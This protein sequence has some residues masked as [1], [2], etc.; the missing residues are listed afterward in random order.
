MLIEPVM[1]DSC[2]KYNGLV[3][4]HAFL[5]SP[6]VPAFRPRV[7]NK[8]KSCIELLCSTSRGIFSV[9]LLWSV[10]SGPVAARQ[11]R[12]SH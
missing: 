8:G 10:G 4:T 6:R 7:A 12:P 3:P 9:V 2:A 1:H 5:R 11:S